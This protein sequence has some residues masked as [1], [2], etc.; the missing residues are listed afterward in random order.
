MCQPEPA[1]PPLPAALCAHLRD[2]AARYRDDAAGTPGAPPRGVLAPRSAEEAAEI[3]RLLQEAGLAAVVQGGRTGLSGGARVQPGELVLSTERLTAPPTID[4]VAG[5]MTVGAGVVLEAAQQAARAA[6]LYLAADLGARGSATLGG[7][8]ATNAGGP[9]ALRYGTFRQQVLGVEGVLP[10]GTIVRRLGGLYKDN[11]G[12]DLS[13]YLVGSEGILGLVTRLVLRLHPAP[14]AR[15][16]AVCTLE[17]AA[18]ALALLPALRAGLGPDLQACELMIDPLLTETCAARGLRPPFADPAPAALLIEVAGADPEACGARLEAVLE[19]ALE[20]G[21]I[22]DAVLSASEAECL[23]L[24][25]LREGCSQFLFQNAGP[26]TSLDLSLPLAAIPA[27][28]AEAE[29][30]CAGR[31]RP[32][33]FGHLGDGN[34]HYVL[35]CPPEAAPTDEIFALTARH[36]GAITAEHGIGADKL[37]WLPLCRDEAEIAAMGRLKRAVD[38][39][40][41]LNPG[42]IL[43]RPCPQTPEARP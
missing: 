1:L 35:A 38:P 6:G 43:S 42:R 37:R 26:I 28:L 17:G 12:L 39:G 16:V 34:L 14:V 25:G 24:W 4:P 33:V 2:D 36:G 29:D 27:F 20:A 18:E 22:R 23:R 11:S 7:M 21:R 13:Q 19:T 40:W 31:A 30:L 8:A 3:L 32:Y 5:T 10:D 41:I 9:L 15:R